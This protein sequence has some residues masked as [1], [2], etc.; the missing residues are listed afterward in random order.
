M[1]IRTCGSGYNLYS[2]TCRVPTKS[3]CVATSTVLHWR[4]SPSIPHSTAAA[5]AAAGAPPLSFSRWPSSTVAMR[6]TA[7]SA[8]LWPS[9]L[10]SAAGGSGSDK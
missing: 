6:P 5:A 2:C 3:T 1:Y 10:P 9:A 4:S 7:C 8:G